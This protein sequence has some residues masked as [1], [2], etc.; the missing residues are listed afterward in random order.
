MQFGGIELAEVKEVARSETGTPC[1]LERRLPFLRRRDAATGVA[2]RPAPPVTSAAAIRPSTP[3]RG[4]DFASE[5]VI[6]SKG[7]SGAWE[8]VDT[9]DADWSTWASFGEGASSGHPGC[10]PTVCL[11]PGS[12]Y[13]F[14]A[15]AGV[16]CGTLLDC[17]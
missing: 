3:R 17:A 13:R 11:A 4:R 2:A 14:V 16:N 8:D 9:G 1:W 10:S 7:S 15:S 6:A 12:D 5:R